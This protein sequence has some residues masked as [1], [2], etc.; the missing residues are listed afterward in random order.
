MASVFAVGDLVEVQPDGLHA[1]VV[2]EH[3]SEPGTLEV[4]Y[5]EPGRGG[6]YIA[7]QSRLRLIEH[8]AAYHT[9]PV[10]EPVVEEPESAE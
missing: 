5:S 9:E 1:V 7:D 4:L 10:S 6:G 3:P 2:R 8:A